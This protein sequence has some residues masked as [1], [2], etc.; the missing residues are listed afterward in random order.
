MN[1]LYSYDLKRKPS[2]T[3]M[4]LEGNLNQWKEE[5]TTWRALISLC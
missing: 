5:A 4:P 2:N 3:Q 1:A